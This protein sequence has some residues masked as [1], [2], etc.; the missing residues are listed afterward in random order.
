MAEII[1][2]SAELLLELANAEPF[3]FP[4]DFPAGQARQAALYWDDLF[5]GWSGY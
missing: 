5:G 1:D 4:S 2:A 3:P